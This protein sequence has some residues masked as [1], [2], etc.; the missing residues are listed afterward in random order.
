MKKTEHLKYLFITRTL[1][2]GGAERFVSTFAS[3]LA[4]QGY[5]IHVLTYEVSE[6][7]YPL[8]DKV[9][10]HVMP[11]VEDSVSGKF[12]RIYRMQQA[13]AE[14]NADI[15]IPFIDTVVVCSYLANLS[16]GKK[17]VYTVRNSP[18]HDDAGRFSKFMRKIIAKRADAIM[19]QNRE[20]EE[21]FS[22][23]YHDRIYIVPN[24][25]ARK[26]CQCQKEN[27]AE[28]LTRLVAIGRLHTQK[29]FPLLISALKRI[30]PEH[31]DVK[32]EIYGEGDEKAALET[33]IARQNLSSVCHLMGRTMD[34]EGVLKETDLFVMSSDYE[35]M[36]NALIEAL[37]MGVPCISSDCRTG[38]RS[39]VEEEQT[40][41]LFETGN[42]DSLS[43]KLTWALQHPKQMNRMGKAARED[44]LDTYKIEKT[45]SSFLEMMDGIF[46]KNR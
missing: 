1:T 24:P 12:L 37:A 45:M 18:W 13:L 26:F 30:A 29:N 3:F 2:G 31:P 28:K 4:D 40:G 7:D 43:E 11:P 9:T 46:G 41:L 39:L 20:Q 19:L 10:R 35:G 36:P 34:V 6:K 33:L 5:D 17:F 15:L 27:Y 14:I 38:P 42:L 8:S 23:S 22:A 21:Y 32:L 44:V 16:L 25:V